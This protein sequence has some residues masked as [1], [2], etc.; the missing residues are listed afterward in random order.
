MRFLAGYNLETFLMRKEI[1]KAM[2]QGEE[3]SP[4]G[5]A[6]DLRC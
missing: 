4:K 6:K 5:L 2:G 1:G 3:K